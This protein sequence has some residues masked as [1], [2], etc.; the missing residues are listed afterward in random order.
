MDHW[1]MT[2]IWDECKMTSRETTCA[3][4]HPRVRGLRPRAMPKTA[5]RG[6]VGEGRTTRGGQ[7][8][9]LSPAVKRRAVDILKDRLSISERLACKV[10]PD[11][12]SI[13]DSPSTRSKSR[14]SDLVSLPARRLRARQVIRRRRC[15][16]YYCLGK[17]SRDGCSSTEAPGF[18]VDAQ[19]RQDN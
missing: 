18:G 7:G 15:R 6:R 4:S 10:E 17:P 11:G 12:L 16:R 14:N 1:K 3:R 13:R 5:G 9:I 19:F 8:K 2:R